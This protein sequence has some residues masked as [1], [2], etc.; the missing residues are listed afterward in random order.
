MGHANEMSPE[1]AEYLAAFAEAEASTNGARAELAQAPQ[2]LAARLVQRALNVLN[3]AGLTEDG[4]WGS[5]S[6]AAFDSWVQTLHA[7]VR[8]G[9]RLSP[10][11]DRRF[12]YVSPDAVRATLEEAGARAIPRVTDRVTT[13]SLSRAAQVLSNAYAKSP[14]W[15]RRVEEYAQRN[16]GRLPGPLVDAYRGWYQSVLALQAIVVQKLRTDRTL[17]AAIQQREAGR[18]SAAML[19]SQL[20]RERPEMPVV[21]AAQTIRTELGAWA[22]AVA[23]LGIVIAVGGTVV[24]TVREARAANDA[25]QRTRQVNS[26][27]AGLGGPGRLRPQDIPQL[28]G[29]AQ[30]QAGE[31]GR[32]RARGERESAESDWLKWTVIGVAVLVAGAL[33]YQFT[34]R[35]GGSTVVV[36][37]DRE[38][39]R[40]RT[41]L[42]ADVED[43]VEAEAA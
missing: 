15:A 23:W 19:A 33:A 31:A 43:D 36:T 20:E 21:Q 3:S 25:L 41:A 42:P 4:D 27:I 32:E 11:Q 29:G 30:Q 37:G 17:A 13:A 14:V 18:T 16:Q 38:R 5:L 39:E 8:S 10:S 9:V 26:I 28:P 35:E 1:L 6:A 7:S 22:Q 2:A 34:R 12:V 24:F 40:A